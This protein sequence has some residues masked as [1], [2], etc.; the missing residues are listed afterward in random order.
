[1]AVDAGVSRRPREGRLC[2]C[3]W[4][5]FFFFFFSCYVCVWST[6]CVVWFSLLFS[7]C[8]WHRYLY[9]FGFWSVFFISSVQAFLLNY[10]IFLCTK[11]NSA[12]T[13]SVVGMYACMLMSSIP[14]PASARSALSTTIHHNNHNS[15]ITPILVSNLLCLWSGAWGALCFCFIFSL[16]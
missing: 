6:S 16:L 12:L 7:V 15:H 2:A 9:D 5:F 3:L 10:S 13:T 8:L 11:T 1:V 14:T 4:F